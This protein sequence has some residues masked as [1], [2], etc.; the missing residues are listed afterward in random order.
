MLKVNQRSINQE[1]ERQMRQLIIKYGIDIDYVAYKA[2]EGD[3]VD[4]L[5]YAIDQGVDFDKAS[6]EGRTANCS[7]SK[8]WAMLFLCLHIPC[9]GH[10]QVSAYIST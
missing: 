1:G 7:I 4:L 9:I 3:N 8:W 10:E 2:I 6:F 5:T